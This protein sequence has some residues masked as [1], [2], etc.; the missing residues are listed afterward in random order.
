MTEKF[1]VY[2]DLLSQ[3]YETAVNTLLTKYGPAQDDYF[4]QASYS[5]F[6]AGTIDKPVN[7]NVDRSDEGLFCHHIRANHYLRLNDAQSIIN[8]HVPFTAQKKDQLVYAD[9]I[10]HMIL[11]ALIAKET[12]Q[13]FGWDELQIY[14][15][16]KVLEWYVSQVTPIRPNE[17]LSYDKAWLNQD[18][19][20]AIAEQSDHTARGEL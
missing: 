8:F 18:E 6:K 12:H 2:R 17:R 20:I 3:T 19:A 10:E 9:V 15:K 13:K 4:Q 14:L 16:P 11:H 7:G 5:A 1:R